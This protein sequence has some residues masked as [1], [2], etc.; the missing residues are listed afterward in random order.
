[1]YIYTLCVYIYIHIYIYY[2]YQHQVAPV[3]HGGTDH[4]TMSLADLGRSSYVSQRGLADTLKRLQDGGKLSKDETT[5]RSSIK[6]AREKEL[7]EMSTRYG[8][9]LIEKEI[10][11]SNSKVYTVSMLN[12]VSLW[13]YMVENCHELQP[14]LDVAF[15]RHMPSQQKPWSLVVYC[16]ELVLGNALR[17]QNNRKLQVFYFSWLELGQEALANEKAWFPLAVI[18]SSKVAELGG[19]T[20]VWPRILDPRIG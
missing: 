4:G 10:H 14:L 12:P 15:Q 19:V 18:R 7:A 13:T 5:S 3:S 6:R 16:D 9:L 1:M 17:H 11:G 8:P 20:V 2:I